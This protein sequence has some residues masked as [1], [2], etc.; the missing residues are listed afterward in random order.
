MTARSVLTF[1]LAIAAVLL[2]AA[3]SLAGDQYPPAANDD[4]KSYPLDTVPVANPPA[5]RNESDVTPPPSTLAVSR[6]PVTKQVANS[7]PRSLSTQDVNAP[8]SRTLD[9]Q[10]A[11]VEPRR[12]APPRLGT[13]MPDYKL[14]TGDKI[15]IIVYGEDDLGGEFE[16]DGSGFVRLPLIG[17]V[18]AAGFTIRDFEAEVT[19]QLADGYVNN[20]RVSADVVAYRPFFIIGEVNKP[21][22]YPYQNDMNLLTAVALAGGYTYR[23]DDTDIY[24]RRSGSTDEKEYPADATTKIQPGDIIRVSERYF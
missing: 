15:R 14:G 17:Q 5:F 18:P 20:P 16:V 22:Q 7:P 24:I 2:A 1:A 8:R 19:A 4:G 10:T 9:L 21:G 13:S 11:D 3:P 6:E 23:A 12:L